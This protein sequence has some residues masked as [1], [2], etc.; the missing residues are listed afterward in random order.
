MKIKH[1]LL[2]CH[3]NVICF[4][5]KV[6]RYLKSGLS[7]TAITGLLRRLAHIKLKLYSNAESARSHKHISA[8]LQP[9]A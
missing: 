5:Y 8:G 4:W 3:Q 1:W 9:H 7:V 6:A 2:N